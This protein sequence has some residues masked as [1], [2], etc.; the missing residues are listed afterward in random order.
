MASV[1]LVN[2]YYY[3]MHYPSISDYNNSISFRLFCRGIIV[4]TLFLIF[5]NEV[6]IY[7]IA[8]SSWKSIDCKLGKSIVYIL[9][10]N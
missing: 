5:F 4:V 10:E 7:Y 9:H 6:L 1:R 3:R 2:R 8:Q